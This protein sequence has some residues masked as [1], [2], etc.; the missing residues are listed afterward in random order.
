MHAHVI[1]LLNLSSRQAHLITVTAIRQNTLIHT[2]APALLVRQYPHRF[3]QHAAN[4]LFHSLIAFSGAFIVLISQM[5]AVSA[6]LQ[7]VPRGSLSLSTL[8]LVSAATP[9]VTQFIPMEF[10][11]NVQQ[12]IQIADI[13]KRLMFMMDFNV[14]MDH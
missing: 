12:A 1:L 13:V 10:A 4:A 2:P 3:Y 5:L 6:H 14:N 7:P 9:A 11:R 8:H